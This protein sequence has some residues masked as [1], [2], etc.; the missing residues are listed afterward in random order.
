MMTWS[1]LQPIPLDL[2]YSA[3]AFQPLYPPKPNQTTLYSKSVSNNINPL[4]SNISID[5]LHTPFWVFPL[6]LTRRI[7]LTLKTSLF[8]DHFCFLMILIYE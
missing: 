8:G 5:I 7:C 6:M 4:L 2:E 1:D 3:L